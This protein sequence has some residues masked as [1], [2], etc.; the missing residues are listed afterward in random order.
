MAEAYRAFVTEHREAAARLA[1]GDLTLGDALAE[2][3]R[4]FDAWRTFPGLDSDLPEDLLPDDWPRA[5]ATEVFQDL[6]DGLGPL[7]ELRFRQIVAAHDEALAEL[8]THRTTDAWQGEGEEE[9]AERPEGPRAERPDTRVQ[10][11]PPGLTPVP[12]PPSPARR[13]TG[14]RTGTPPAAPPRSRARP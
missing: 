2:R 6:Y 9:T 5:R 7:A 10:G 13:A 14:P 8:T 1:R 3:L 12:H 11:A 4:V